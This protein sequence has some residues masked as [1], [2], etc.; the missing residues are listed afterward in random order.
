MKFCLLTIMEANRTKRKT[1]SFCLW[2]FGIIIFAVAVWLI[3]KSC[4]IKPN[5]HE[6]N[7]L[8]IEVD[9]IIEERFVPTNAKEEVINND[10]VNNAYIKVL[11]EYS[12]TN[13]ENEFFQC[14]YF[15]FDITGDGAPEL[16]IKAGTCEADCT[17]YIYTSAHKLKK[18]YEGDAGHSS[19]YAGENYVIQMC[20]HMGYSTWYKITYNGTIKVSEVWNEDTN[21]TDDDYKMPSESY[22]EMT[23][24]E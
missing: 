13:A 3:A 18:I 17:L 12:Q 23:P 24:Y 7:Q 22:I 5:A 14:E 4:E 21:G 10:V 16:W 9:S 11:D 6:E 15:L 1:A 20:A 19:F 2:I 8:P